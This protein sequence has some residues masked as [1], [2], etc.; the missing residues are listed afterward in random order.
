MNRPVGPLVGMFAFSICLSEIDKR[1]P[2]A[3]NSIYRCRELT[4]LAADRWA[5]HLTL[6]VNPHLEFGM[7]T[8]REIA[9]RQGG[10]AAARD[11]H[12]VGTVLYVIIGTPSFPL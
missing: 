4:R 1:P 7:D 5:R 6:S 2:K 11:T 8:L 9:F 10:T 12:T 3:P